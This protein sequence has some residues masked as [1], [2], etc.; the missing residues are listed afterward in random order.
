[1]T[2]PRVAVTTF[3]SEFLLE[4]DSCTTEACYHV[5][6]GCHFLMLFR[7]RYLIKTYNVDFMASPRISHL[8]TLRTI[9][10][11]GV[12]V[13][14]SHTLASIGLLNL[15]DYSTRPGALSSTEGA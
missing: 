10:H 5:K 11:R 15:N 9:G 13:M 1:M 8:V 3:G 12:G 14:M 2:F 4:W 6:V 7:N